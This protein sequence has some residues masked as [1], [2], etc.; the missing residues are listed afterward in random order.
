MSI[1]V[2]EELFAEV[3]PGVQLCY[4]TFGHARR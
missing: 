1:P 4:Q 3:S 2:S